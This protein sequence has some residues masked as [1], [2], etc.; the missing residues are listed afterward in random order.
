[1]KKLLAM[2]AA[3]GLMA[4]LLGGCNKKEEAPDVV[5]PEGVVIVANEGDKAVTLAEYSYFFKQT[6][7]RVE[8]QM[9]MNGSATEETM[10]DFWQSMGGDGMTME[11]QLREQAFIDAIQCYLLYSQAGE[12]GVSLTENEI[13]DVNQAIDDSVASLEQTPEEIAALFMGAYGVSQEEFKTI[14]HR[15]ET[16]NKYISMLV[17]TAEVSDQEIQAVYNANPTAYDKVRVRHVLINADETMTEEQKTAAKEKAEGILEEIQNGADIGEMAA[18]H[19]Q[20]P[21]SQFNNGEY[22]FARG[23]MVEPFEN[24]SFA[25]AVGD[26]G[27]VQTNYGYHVMELMSSQ[28]LEETWEEIRDILR[29]RSVDEVFDQTAED[30]ITKWQRDTKAAAGITLE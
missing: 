11:A 12:A 30:A 13:N 25:A 20:D 28:S 23:T 21:G 29:Q 22:T 24:W 3:I 18:L 14:N 16:I 15:I 26:Q 9:L 4:G 19:S 8:E 10:I 1:M 17:T 5:V 2:L 27:I 7:T 6:Q